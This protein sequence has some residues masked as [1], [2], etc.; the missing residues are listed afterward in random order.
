MR[1][2]QHASRCLIRSGRVEAPEFTLCTHGS[3]FNFI[4]T[5]TVTTGHIEAMVG[6]KRSDHAYIIIAELLR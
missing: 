1:D 5:D 3:L 6:N 2:C 4:R